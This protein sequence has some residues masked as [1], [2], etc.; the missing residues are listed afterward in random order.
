MQNVEFSRETLEKKAPFLPLRLLLLSSK[1]LAVSAA[2]VLE[3]LCLALHHMA[4]SAGSLK[5]PSPSYCSPSCGTLGLIPCVCFALPSGNS[6][7]CV[8]NVPPTDLLPRAHLFC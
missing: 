4:A 2:L 6:L 8:W 7:E 5:N 1:S 3:P